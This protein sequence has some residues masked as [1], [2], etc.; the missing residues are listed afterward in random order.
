MSREAVQ[1]ETGIAQSAGKE[2]V[3][4][5]GHTARENSQTSQLLGM[6]QLLF[7]APPLGHVVCEFEK[8]RGAACGI[9]AQGPAAGNSQPGPVAPR[10][11]QFAFPTSC[12]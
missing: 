9:P 6:L 4:V 10:V 5:V 11:S 2:V 7:D 1:H 12:R 8:S 3:E